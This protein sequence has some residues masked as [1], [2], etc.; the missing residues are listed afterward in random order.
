[1]KDK[2]CFFIGN[3]HA[4]NSIKSKLFEVTEKH[5]TEYGVTTFFA[6]HYGNFDRLVTSVLRELKKNYLNINLYMLAPYALTIKAEAPTDFIGTFYP[7]GLET[8]PKPFAI[9][10][11]NRFMIKKC[12]YL[13]S[14]CPFSYGNTQK[15]VKY[16]KNREKQGL[17]K[18][19]L[20]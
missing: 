15:F 13:I 10:Q 4:P 11:A 20:L 5:I 19:T 17:I 16:A 14:Y 3:R 6:G 8:V 1:M 18:V 12:D 2:T 9:I 7:D